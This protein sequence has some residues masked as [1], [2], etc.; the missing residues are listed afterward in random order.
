M[1]LLIM[2][3]GA[4]HG[5]MHS[6]DVSHVLSIAQPTNSQWNARVFTS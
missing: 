3:A 1:L 5:T 6:V 2:T 4:V